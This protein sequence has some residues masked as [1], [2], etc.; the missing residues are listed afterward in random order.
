[1]V[2]FKTFTNAKTRN[3]RTGGTIIAGVM[4]ISTLAADM[5]Y[6]W[7]GSLG[8]GTQEDIKKMLLMQPAYCIW[9]GKR[10]SVKNS[11]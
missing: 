4:P 9:L 7:E 11:E 6:F 2:A 8:R 3:V 5:T 10:S 1:M